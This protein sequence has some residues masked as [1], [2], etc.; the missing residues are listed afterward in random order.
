MRIGT[1]FIDELD[2]GLPGASSLVIEGESNS[3][4]SDFKSIEELRYF[5]FGATER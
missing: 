4:R 3:I 2:M 1:Y 5:L